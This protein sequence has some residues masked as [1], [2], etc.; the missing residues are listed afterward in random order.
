MEGWKDG[1]VEGWKD[2]RLEGWEN[3]R[4]EG[5]KGGRVEGWKDGRIEEWNDGRRME[6]DLSEPLL[7][8]FASFKSFQPHRDHCALRASFSVLSVKW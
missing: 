4:V 6:G 8:R 7:R 5:W 1:R 3:G 2:G